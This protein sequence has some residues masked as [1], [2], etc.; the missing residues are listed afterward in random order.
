MLS[1]QWNEKKARK[2]E[3]GEKMISLEIF[4]Q[5]QVAWQQ[6]WDMLKFDYD[7]AFTDDEKKQVQ[8]KMVELRSRRPIPPMDSTPQARSSSP[9]NEGAESGANGD[10]DPGA[11][12]D[13]VDVEE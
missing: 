3:M 9:P 1:Q 5:H 6:E 11:D 12:A 4:H 2:D 8:T 7:V 13:P 10:A